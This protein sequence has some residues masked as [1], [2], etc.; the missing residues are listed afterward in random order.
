MRRL[1]AVLF[2]LC[3]AT[4]QANPYAVGEVMVVEDTTGAQHDP[5]QQNQ[6]LGLATTLCQFAAKGLYTKYPDIYDGVLMF[7]TNPMNTPELGIQNVMRGNIVRQTAQG[8]SDTPFLSLTGDPAVAYGSPA[9]L[10]QCVYMGSL[11]QLPQNPDDQATTLFGGFVPLPMGI[12][13]TELMGHEYGHHWL[14]WAS[15][16]KGLGAGK[17][18]LMR[19]DEGDMQ[20]P[21]GQQPNG[22][23]NHYSDARSV[24]YGSF[25]TPKGGDQY[26][27][28]GGVRGYNEFDQ[29]FMGLRAPS[30]VSPILI[31]DDGSGR[32]AA[33]QPLWRTSTLDITGTPVM[34]DVQDVIRSM[35]PRIPAYPSAKN[36]H[37]VAFVL[38]T[39]AG[40]TATAAEIAKVNAYRQRFETWFAPATD[41]RG[42]MDTRLT[43]ASGCISNTDA[44][45]PVVDAGT[46]PVDGGS[47][48]VDAG[49]AD[50]GW[51]GE[52]D[53]DAG[54]DAGQT[55]PPAVAD[56]QY[57]K[58]DPWADTGKLKPGCGCNG[59]SGAAMV[60]GALALFVLVRRRTRAPRA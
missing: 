4:A 16:D 20:D 53:P 44:G 25:I 36:C 33:V 35:G 54:E 55:E 30:E 1:S 38:V 52:I 32:G 59:T 40:H 47:P 27:L 14:V 43:G 2:V 19:G 6:M 31:V 28:N 23:W 15:F 56:P 24:M 42:S 37:R 8:L 46:P 48:A 9:E 21:T 11:G 10:D 60:F 51:V 45:T 57:D 34:V 26:Q 18:Y 39:H 17:Q 49:P 58:Y 5:E 7:T 50:A 29:Y 13:A 3:A 12:T 41:N 22:H